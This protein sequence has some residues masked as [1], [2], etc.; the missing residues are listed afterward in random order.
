M[1]MRGLDAEAR[2]N[3]RA[4]VDKDDESDHDGTILPDEIDEDELASHTALLTDVDLLWPVP[5]TPSGSRELLS[6]RSSSLTLSPGITVEL[7]DGDF[8]MITTI[9]QREETRQVF[10]EGQIFRRAR[11]LNGLLE[12]KKNEIVWIQRYNPNI[13][14]DTFRQS[15]QRV[16]TT[17]VIQIRDLILTN[18]L[19]PHG[20]YRSEPVHVRQ[21]SSEI[22]ET[23]R[24]TCRWKYL[25]S[26]DK[27]GCL[28]AL[29]A[30]ETDAWYRS[31]CVLL[32]STYRGISTGGGS[33]PDWLAGERNFD[34][35]E[36]TRCN[37][38]DPFGLRQPTDYLEGPGKRYTFGDGF[39]GAGGVSRGAKAAGLRV[40]W[41]FDFNR[42][43]I[44]SYRANFHE[45]M[46]WC[47]PAH[48]FVT[49]IPDDVK[50]DILH[51]SPP[52]QTFS[53]A[54]VHPGQNDDANE[55][56][57]FALEEILKK[58]KPRVVMVEETFGLLRTGYRMQWFRAMIQIFTRLGFSVRWK[59]FK[60]LDF[61]LPGRRERLFIF[62][63]WLVNLIRKLYGVD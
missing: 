46:C 61:G 62:A 22:L 42:A 8:L 36:R 51:I 32:K 43:A 29:K 5:Q 26:G 41:G 28:T 13:D 10:L 31:P 44:E 23:Y 33:C 55:A 49:A 34:I 47:C 54:H 14:G 50:V 38:L 60:L 56:S 11:C 27:E 57:F 39:C 7:N 45:T 12:K 24:L 2:L 52:C 30:D 63:S 21:P 35:S 4:T 3:D 20:S 19:Y 17:K 59:I 53:P 48:T 9:T 6:Y 37:N 40:L 58:V 16:S 18:Q 1:T 25:S 15:L